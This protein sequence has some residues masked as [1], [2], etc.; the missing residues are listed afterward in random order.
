MDEFE[1]QPQQP[2]S[3]QDANGT[4][5]RN[6][7]K[8]AVVSSA[9]AAAAVG[10]AG[11]AA[12]TL[13]S[14][15]PT[16]LS[17]LLVLDSTLVSTKNACFTHTNASLDDNT[18]SNPFSDNSSLFYWA[19]F[20]LPSHTATDQFTI[21]VSSGTPFPST[22]TY[23]NSNSVEV[24]PGLSGCPTSQPANPVTPPGSIASLPITFSVG[25]GVTTVLLQL[26]LNGS[27]VT[28][29]STFTLTTEI[30]GPGGYDVTATHTAYFQ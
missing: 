12:A 29:G 24:Y 18:P 13:S 14:R 17:K 10:G 15:A 8:V 16:G 28:P 23:Q 7:L 30:T 6:F 22:I 27:S 20:T 19:W 25:A 26:H 9:A 1:N 4:S 21:K 2:E 5:R 11:V 3:A